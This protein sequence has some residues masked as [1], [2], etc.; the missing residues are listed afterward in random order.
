MKEYELCMDGLAL[1][2]FNR[3]I[4]FR[5]IIILKCQR[6]RQP[7]FSNFCLYVSTYTSKSFLTHLVKN[8]TALLHN[9]YVLFRN[10]ARAV[11]IRHPISGCT[12]SV[13]KMTELTLFENLKQ[14]NKNIYIYSWSL[15]SKELVN[16]TFDIM[17]ADDRCPVVRTVYFKLLAPHCSGFESRQGL[18]IFM[19]LSHPTSLMNVGC[20]T[21]VLAGTWMT[22]LVFFR[23][24]KLK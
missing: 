6:K 4:P 18:F 17:K 21:P 5:N 19:W 20:P 22:L 11:N 24:P 3:W 2:L 13:N 8:L 12:A 1:Y 16:L 9:G 10:V 7:R 14:G 23:L 15:W